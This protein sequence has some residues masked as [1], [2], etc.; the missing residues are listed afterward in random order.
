[1]PRVGKKLKVVEV[2]EK[3]EN[4]TFEEKT[5]ES[6]TDAQELTTIKEEIENE[7]KIENKIEEKMEEVKEEI[8]DIEE[9]AKPDR[10]KK[11][12]E[13]MREYRKVKQAEQK[14]MKEDLKQKT[15]MIEKI[16]ETPV[17][18][19]SRG[20]S[21]DTHG[22]ERPVEKQPQIIE[23]IIEKEPKTIKEAPDYNNI[24]EEIILKEIRKRQVSASEQR[25][26]RKKESMNKLKMN[27][28]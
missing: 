19:F 2:S 23:R 20:E 8:Q 12:A 17:E 1:M 15:E 6:I 25:Q 11:S 26:N 21:L 10:K 7:E 5:A 4:E 24:P 27:I 16:S 9:V 3:C 14:K 13:Y 28:A 18:R 22:V